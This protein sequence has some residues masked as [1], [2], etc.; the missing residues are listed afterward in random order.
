MA[1][2]YEDIVEYINSHKIRGRYERKNIRQWMINNFPDRTD[3]I[4]FFLPI[5]KTENEIT[6]DDFKNFVNND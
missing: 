2:T 3:G 1:K 6:Y 4:M 5:I